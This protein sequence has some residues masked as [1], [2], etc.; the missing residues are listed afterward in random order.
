MK[1]WL[2]ALVAL[3]LVPCAVSATS[4]VKWEALPNSALTTKAPDPIA[5][6]AIR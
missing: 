3:I 1:K 2:L 4:T 6:T 5:S